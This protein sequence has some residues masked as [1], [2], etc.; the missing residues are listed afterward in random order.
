[1]IILTLD[2]RQMKSAK[3]WCDQVT[4]YLESLGY[5]PRLTDDSQWKTWATRV[6]G[7]PEIS[8]RNPPRP[9]QYSNWVDWA[10]RFNQC[11]NG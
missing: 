7:I 11:L 10:V 8:S 1:M 9:D 2:P 5:I 4:P 6:Q 3:E